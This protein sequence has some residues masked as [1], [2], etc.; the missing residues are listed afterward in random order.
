VL[1]VDD[2]DILTS[3]GVPAGLD[4]C[5]HVVRRDHGA[6]V[7]A[8]IARWTVVAPY[9]DGGQESARQEREDRCH[10]MGRQ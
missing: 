10:I 1:N 6:A 5:L 3:A 7:A 4:L 8:A 2:G 9:R